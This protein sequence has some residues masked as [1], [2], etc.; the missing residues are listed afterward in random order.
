MHAPGDRTQTHVA[1][2]IPALNDD[3]EIGGRR[4]GISEPAEDFRITER[5]GGD[6]ASPGY[7]RLCEDSVPSREER[8][9]GKRVRSLA[10]KQNA[11]RYQVDRRITTRVSVASFMH[12]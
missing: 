12:G 4:G 3:A 7:R 8:E 6:K 10:A 1:R 5:K 11:S 9:G 2:R